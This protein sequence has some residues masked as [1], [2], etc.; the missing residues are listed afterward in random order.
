MGG[1]ELVPFAK[2]EDAARFVARFGG[3]LARF[4]EVPEEYVLGPDPSPDSQAATPN[5]EQGHAHH[6]P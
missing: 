6:M 5:E 3:R 2:Q 4:G 1:R